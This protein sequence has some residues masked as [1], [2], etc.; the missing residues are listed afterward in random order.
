MS[1]TTRAGAAFAVGFIAPLNVAFACG[2]S[3]TRGSGDLGFAVT[4]SWFVGTA[5][6]V[7]AYFV[8]I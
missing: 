1:K 5:L 3:F 8:E 6:G 2:V 4:V 7:A